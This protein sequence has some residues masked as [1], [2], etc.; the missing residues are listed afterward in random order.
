MI[1][2]AYS[3]QNAKDLKRINQVYRSGQLS[4]GPMCREFEDRFKALHGKK[5]A[6]FV[7]SGTDA[8]RLSLLALKEKY[9]WPDGSLVVVPDLTFVATVNVVIQAGLVPLFVNV[10]MYDYN[11]NSWHID[12]VLS[13]MEDRSRVKAIL[14]V[15]LFGQVCDMKGVMRVADKYG[16]RVLEDSCES[17]LSTQE[18]RN[19]GT[20]GD[21]SCFSTYQCHILATGV[22]G[23]AMTDDSEIHEL[24]RSYANH[25][26]DVAYLPGFRKPALSKELVSKRFRFVRDGYSCR[27]SEFEA[28]LGIGQLE[29]LD[30]N[31]K[32]RRAIAELMMNYLLPFNDKVVL[33]TA[34]KG[35]VHSY[36]MFPVVIREDADVSKEDLVWHLESRGIETRDMMPITNQVVFKR[37][38]EE[39]MIEGSVSNWINTKGFYIPCHPGMTK[40]DVIH[41]FLAFLDFL[42]K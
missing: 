13:L 42:K 2:F 29:R 20:F 38:F 35:R 9:R 22:G 28:A 39:K 37:F 25:G 18:G 34:Q 12:H 7:N 14:P 11:I 16:L 19:C 4:P 21:V 10:G 36:M 31:L 41:I 5:H 27:P 26:R 24:I 6:V 23:L 32:K 33:P 30:D 15:H 40:K 3:D 1:S 8:L 17:V